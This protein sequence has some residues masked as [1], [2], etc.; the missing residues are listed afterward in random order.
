MQG[1][2]TETHDELPRLAPRPLDSHKGDY[3]RVLLIGGSLGMAGAISLAGLAA[4]RSGAGLVTLA[5]PEVCLSVVASF[6][7]SYMTYP[8]P[9]DA[10]GRLTISAREEIARLAAGVDCLAVGPGLGRSA[11]LTALVQWM[12]QVLPNPMLIDADGLYALSQPGLLWRDAGGPRVLTPHPGELRRLV[13]SDE[14]TRDGLELRAAQ[15]ALSSQAVV[16]LK[17]HRTW[18]TDG[19]QGAHNLTGNPGMATGGSGD[20]LTGVITALIGQ[21][22]SPFQAARLGVY[23]HGLAGDLA[24]EQRGQVSLI[25]SDLPAF[26]SLAFRHLE[27]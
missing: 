14:E 18:I 16:V 27:S 26:L 22:L 3:G 12:Y 9:C 8:L 20:V 10:R 6:E 7:P 15:L 1:K 23:L 25:A 5:V 11:P 2:P 19:R 4:L 13:D 24:A 21:G 17:G